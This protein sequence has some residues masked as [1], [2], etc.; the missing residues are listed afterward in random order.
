MRQKKSGAPDKPKKPYRDFPL[1]PHATRRWAKE[2]SWQDALLCPVGQPDEAIQKFLAQRDDLYAGRTPRPTE[3]GPVL[4]ELVNR[5]LTTKQ[6]KLDNG[7]LGQRTF[8]DYHSCCQRVVD[9][10]HRE[11]R[12]ADI[13]TRDFE[14]LRLELAKTRGP[15]ALAGEIQ[16]VRTLFKY[17][18][19]AG[20]IDAPIR[21]GPSFRKPSRKT[22]REARQRKGPRMFEADQ[23][24]AMLIEAEQPLHAMILLGINCGFGNNDV[25]R[26]PKTAVDMENGWISFPRP[27]TAVQRRCP[28]W[29]ETIASL[30]AALAGRRA[31]V[32]WSDDVLFFLTG[33]GKPWANDKPGSPVSKAMATLLKKLG[34]H[35][36]GLGFYALRHTLETIGGESRDQVAV[37]FIMG[38]A[39][40]DMASHYRER[41]SDQRLIRVTDTVRSW[42]FDTTE[43]DESR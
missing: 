29:P 10:F 3:P 13:D 27:K 12:I 2:D 6:D 20:I 32:E 8:H 31:P 30:R 14:L 36:P 16:R 5:F 43:A 25:G 11:R 9:F 18:Y 41:I 38:H 34:M 15:V 35:R 23:I 26:L 21:F 28:L 17:A 24:R 42:L 7:E 1:F 19:D 22:I 40:E 33:G 4:R 39:R 37:D